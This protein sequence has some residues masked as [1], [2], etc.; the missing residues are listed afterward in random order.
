[1]AR[2]PAP[3]SSRSCSPVPCTDDIE[4]SDAAEMDIPNSEIG[5]V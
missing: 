1:M 4:G 2:N 3:S 5:S